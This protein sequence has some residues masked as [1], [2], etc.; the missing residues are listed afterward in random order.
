LACELN[1]KGEWSELGY[2]EQFDP[3]IAL[4]DNVERIRVT[5]LPNSKFIEKYERLYKTSGYLWLSGYL[6]TG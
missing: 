4:S 6:E 2:A 5:E 3:F 1:G